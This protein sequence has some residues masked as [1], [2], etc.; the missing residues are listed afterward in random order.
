MHQRSIHGYFVCVY[1]GKCGTRS[2]NA[3]FL[4][5]AQIVDLLH[6]MYAV[7]WCYAVLVFV[8][9]FRSARWRY[10]QQYVFESWKRFIISL[11]RRTHVKSVCIDDSKH[12]VCGFLYIISMSLLLVVFSCFVLFI[13]TIGTYCDLQLTQTSLA[14]VSRSFW[15]FLSFFVVGLLLCVFFSLSLSTFLLF[16][17]CFRALLPLAVVLFVC[18]TVCQPLDFWSL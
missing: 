17:V 4:M 13:F 16:F 15:F 6:C 9:F 1:S 10:A 11:M 8:Q 2:A 7:P 3:L 18:R 12:F 14:F 5:P